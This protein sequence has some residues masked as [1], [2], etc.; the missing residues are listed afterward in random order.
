MLELI[1]FVGGID[2]LHKREF[3]PLLFGI[4]PHDR[5]PS[6]FVSIFAALMLIP[7]PLSLCNLFFLSRPMSQLTLFIINYI[8]A[9]LLSV[10]VRRLRERTPLTNTAVDRSTLT[11]EQRTVEARIVKRTARAIFLLCLGFFI[12]PLQAATFIYADRTRLLIDEFGIGERFRDWIRLAVTGSIVL[13]VLLCIPLWMVGTGM[14]LPSIPP[15]D[16]RLPIR[17]MSLAGNRAVATITHDRII[18]PRWTPSKSTPMNRVATDQPSNAASSETAVPTLTSTPFDTDAVATLVQEALGEP[19][20]LIPTLTPQPTSTPVDSTYT[21]MPVARGSIQVIPSWNDIEKRF[22][23][24]QHFG[25]A[26]AISGDLIVVGESHPDGQAVEESGVHFFRLADDTLLLEDSI[27]SGTTSEPSQ[28]GQSVAIDGETAIIASPIMIVDRAGGDWRVRWEG[29]TALEAT[30]VDISGNTAIAG[31]PDEGRVYLFRHTENGWVEESFI[32]AP[33]NIF[34]FGLAVSIHGDT[35]AV[36]GGTSSQPDTV[37]IYQRTGGVWRNVAQVTSHLF[38]QT[39]R[40]VM[41]RSVSIS[42]RF[43]FVSS[44]QGTDSEPALLLFEDTSTANDWSTLRHVSLSDLPG[45]PQNRWVQYGATDGEVLAVATRWASGLSF[46]RSTDGIIYLYRYTADGWE[47]AGI[48]SRTVY[49]GLD[50][51]LFGGPAIAV[52]GNYVVTGHIR[53]IPRETT[54]RAGV[55]Y[56][57]EL[58]E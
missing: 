7:L 8:G 28:L 25:G 55:V 31:A 18:S 26:V 13:P 24:T 1:L 16:L 36:M 48:I 30:S 32:T 57:L 42:D 41:R 4:P 23:A 17:P 29:N 27:L 33:A 43:V 6:E 34:R 2:A 50:N 9:L 52:D 53:V 15:V 45:L 5:V 54:P 12:P 22:D 19:A 35:L 51:V 14:T 37:I 44:G 10:V 56:V 58:A 38:G 20:T 39:N 21:S 40:N 46:S 49:A 3:H 11:L 47:R